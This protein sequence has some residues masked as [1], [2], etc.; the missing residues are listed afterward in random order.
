MPKIAEPAAKWKYDRTVDVIGRWS[1][2]KL[3]LLRRYASEYS[4]ILSN[5]K[6][7]RH[8]YIDAFAGG[9]VHMS[10]TSA[11][12]VP[13]SPLNALSVQPPFNEYHF[14]ELDTHKVQALHEIAGKRKDIQVYQGDCNKILAEEVFPKAR[15]EDYVRALCFLDPYGLQL[16]WNVIKAA[17]QSRSIEVF[18]NFPIA[19]INRNV[20]RKNPD[21]RDPAQEERMN[22]FWG[23]DSWK[24][25][26][27]E[28]KSCL[29]GD[30]E[31]KVDNEKVAEAFR[32]R[33]KTV[34]GFKEVP[35]PCPMKNSK[36]AVVYYLYFAS[37]KSVA[38]GIVKHIFDHFGRT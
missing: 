7:L 14:I 26:A 4:K 16:D 10:R 6:K 31:E 13:G 24:K 35:K 21:E 19:D 30:M 2:V 23:D 20:L 18:I 38:S 25:S 12:L 34:A 32:Q 37:A 3:E 15:Y 5:Q 33:L 22:F 9:G 27:Y 1:E 8:I 28:P 17:G 36:K 29:Y 11:T